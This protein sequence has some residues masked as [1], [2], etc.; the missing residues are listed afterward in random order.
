MTSGTGARTV[1]VGL[2]VA[3]T[4]GVSA[5]AGPLED[6]LAA[7]DRG[8]YT[9]ALSAWLPLA[10]RG[11][12]DAQFNLGAMYQA[13]HGVRRDYPEAAKWYRRSAE[14]GNAT[15]QFR[16]GEMYQ[17][18]L[19]VSQD[20]DEAFAWYLRAA[21]RGHSFA[22]YNLGVMSQRGQ[23]TPQDF[24]Q[25]Y[26]WLDLA[27]VRAEPGRARANAERA[28]DRLARRMTAAQVKEAKR[29]AQEWK[30]KP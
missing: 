22:Q 5:V 24:V 14:R 28:R 23:G 21:E 9:A 8:D 11:D 1:V 20:E 26:K 17:Q 12:R 30:R 2:I 10:E 7:Y 4:L 6:G 3:A 19:G 29:L 15:A 16:L 18:G 13:G 27:A 25:A